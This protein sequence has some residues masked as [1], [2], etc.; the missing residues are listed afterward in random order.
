MPRTLTCRRSAFY[1]ELWDACLAVSDPDKQIYGWGVT[2]NRSGDG[3]WFRDRVPH[4]WGAYVQDETGHYVTVDTPADGRGHDG[5]D[6]PLH[7]QEVGADAAAGRARL[8]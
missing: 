6:Q 2:I 3:D 4:G 5:H 1:P 7:G 8:D